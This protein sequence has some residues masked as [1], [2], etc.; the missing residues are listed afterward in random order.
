[1]QSKSLKE[2]CKDAKKRLKNGFWQE[3]FD[4]RDKIIEKAQMNG[5]SPEKVK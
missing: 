4:S 5:G 2:Y 1:M 3:Y